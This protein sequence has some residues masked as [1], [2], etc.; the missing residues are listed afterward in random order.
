[1]NET[2]AAEQAIRER[3]RQRA[4]ITFAEFMQMALYHPVGGY[5][6]SE[7]PFGAA[8]DFYTSPAVHP[9][10]GALLAV[11]L[12]CMWMRLGSPS[13]F[14]VVEMGAGNGLLA[15]D[16]CAAAEELCDEFAHKLRYVCIERY[17]PDDANRGMSGD[18][19]HIERLIAD[20][21]P[22]SDVV[23]CFISNEFADALPVHRFQMSGREALEVYVAL[24][25]DGKFIEILVEPSTPTLNE[26]LDGLGFA[27]EDRH[28]GEVNL[29][30]KPWLD[31]VARALDKG[32]VITIDYGYEAAEL[33]SQRRRFGT[34]QTYY[35]HTEGSS[36]YQRIGRQDIS[37]HVDFSLLQS[38]GYAAGLN[39]LAY[40]T[41]AELLQGLGLNDL[42]HRL[43]QE[44]MPEY[45][46][47]A[48]LM[49]MRELVKP[50]GL[51]GFK[52][53]F[54]EKATG[55]SDLAQIQPGDAPCQTMPLPML[56]DR[57]MPLIQGRFPHTSWETPLL[58]DDWQQDIR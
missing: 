15:N 10:F 5:Y 26:R 56:T 30:I 23:G 42:L 17:S 9:A 53:L 54:Q 29:Q 37:A 19:P 51:G 39:T 57:H 4:R 8:G 45:E 7:K 50:E 38:E 43:R 44:P 13:D 35:R 20:T 28:C 16:I 12:Q 21:L 22:L 48:N 18:A 31:D 49:S 34:L 27:L 58:W 1:M 46:R 40:M 24:D 25:K 2:T 52:V 11:Q 3:I 47:N 33:Y 55:V 14:T 41:Q 6:T 36:P 32:F